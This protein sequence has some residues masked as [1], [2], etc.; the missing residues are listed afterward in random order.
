MGGGEGGDGGEEGGRTEVDSRRIE[1]GEE[2]GV[3]WSKARR[4]GGGR[5]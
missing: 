1:V 3:R 4:R 5:G 2:G